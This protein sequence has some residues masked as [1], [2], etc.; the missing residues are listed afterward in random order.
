MPFHFYFIADRLVISSTRLESGKQHVPVS[1]PKRKK[2]SVCGREM[3][4]IF[5]GE[6]LFSGEIAA[7]SILESEV[8][9]PECG[10]VEDGEWKNHEAFEIDFRGVDR[11]T[12]LYRY[13]FPYLPFTGK[14]KVLFFDEWNEVFIPFHEIEFQIMSRVRHSN[15]EY[16]VKQLEERDALVTLWNFSSGKK[17]I[18]DWKI[19]EV[20]DIA[21]VLDPSRDRIL[22]VGRDIKEHFADESE[23]LIAVAV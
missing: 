6:L 3:M 2:C 15:T 1:F 18:E 23:I 7:L 4:P 21:L 5:E 19:D 13:L 8:R 20:A 16:L 14:E 9:C 12:F 10:R 11:N 17:L 22:Y